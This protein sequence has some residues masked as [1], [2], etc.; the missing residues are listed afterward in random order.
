M[1]THT[2]YSGDSRTKLER[3]AAAA[4]RAGI[5]V[6][7]VTDHDTIEGAL[8]LRELAQGFRVVV[9]EEIGS[10]D[11][12]LIGLF[13][14][15]PVPRGLSVEATIARVHD[16]GGIVYVPHPFSRNRR[17][18]IRRAALERVVKSIDALEVFNA[19]EALGRDNRRALE[20]ALAQGIAAG[21]GSDAHRAPELGRAYV[22]LQHDFATAAEFLE[23]LRGARVA[24][25]LSGMGVHVG[26][27]YDVFRKWL[28]RRRG[29]RG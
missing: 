6:A 13:L 4:T 24:G 1:H 17:R 3:Y 2:E 5:D 18:H 8:R 19:R 21:A 26:T 27:R 20:F 22:E 16:Q 29:A 11:G 23:A 28:R 9:G 15:R 7:C 10:A 25:R 14:E 12:E